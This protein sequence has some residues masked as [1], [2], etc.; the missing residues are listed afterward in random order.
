M[1]RAGSA[2]KQSDRCDEAIF[3]FGEDTQKRSSV[4]IAPVQISVAGGTAAF[5]GGL[6][7]NENALA[8]L[9]V[10]VTVLI[11]LAVWAKSERYLRTCGVDCPTDISASRK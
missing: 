7:M 6:S 1:L 5:D 11:S 3:P 8:K 9:V 2:T 4:L 10:I